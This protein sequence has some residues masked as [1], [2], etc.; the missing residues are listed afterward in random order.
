MCIMA[1][2]HGPIDHAYSN[3]AL[4]RSIGS[5]GRFLIITGAGMSEESGIPT[6]RDP[7]GW[8]KTYKPEELATLGA[9]N[10]DPVEVWQWYEMRRGIVARAAPN[11]GHRALA[12]AEAEGRRVAIIT[13]NVD[14]LHERAG[15]RE[16]IHAH[17]N[18]WQLRCMN[19][20]TVFEDRRVPLP[21]LPPRCPDGHLARPNIVWWD[22]NL[23][24]PVVARIDALLDESFDIALIVGTEATFD[25]VRGWALR[26]KSRHA[27]LVEVNPRPTALTEHVG[28]RIDWKAAEV[29][30]NVLAG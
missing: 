12:R 7:E 13:Q 21:V 8:W 4:I 10:R 11:A 17:G 15:S 26:A 16:I 14:D 23:D 3:A 30:N 1:Q 25:Y 6:F 28:A 20:E 5:A 19:E 9:F 27:L 24:P 22:E 18:I 2:E 29:L